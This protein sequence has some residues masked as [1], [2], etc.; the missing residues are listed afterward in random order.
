MNNDVSEFRD[1]VP[2]AIDCGCD[3][4]EAGGAV[5]ECEGKVNKGRGRAGGDEDEKEEGEVA[6]SMD[7]AREDKE[8]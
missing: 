7:E 6:S 3:E 4:N 1:F 5:A 8:E 2:A